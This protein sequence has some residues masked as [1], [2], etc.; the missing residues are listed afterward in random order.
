M[1]ALAVV[2]RQSALSLWLLRREHHAVNLAGKGGS[3]GDAGVE[4]LA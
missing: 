1:R 4:A 3:V 2:K